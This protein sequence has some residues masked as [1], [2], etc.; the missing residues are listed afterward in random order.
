[1]QDH[2]AEAVDSSYRAAYRTDGQTESRGSACAT[3]L[4]A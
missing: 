4:G 3:L 1:M 2:A